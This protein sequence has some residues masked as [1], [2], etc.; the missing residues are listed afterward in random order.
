MNDNGPKYGFGEFTLD[1]ERAC[2]LGSGREVKLRPKVYDALRY[3][4]ENPGRLIRKEELIQALWPGSFVTDDSLVQCMVELRRALNDGAQAI[5]QTVPR[6]GY[7][8]TAAVRREET[9]K[10]APAA[11][12]VL[13]DLAASRH[14]L[15]IPRTP[16]IGRER[17][18]TA[19]RTLLLDPAIRLVTLTGAGGSGKTRLGL[20]VA[21][22]LAERFDG[23]VTFVALASIRDPAMAPVA[24]A[25]RRPSCPRFAEAAF[26]RCRPRAGAP[27]A[28]QSGAHS[29]GLLG[30]RRTAG[31]RAGPEISRN[32]QD[33]IACLR[34]A[35]I[36]GPAAGVARSET[37]KFAQR[38]TQ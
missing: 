27:G 15:P 28:G 32:Q 13:A 6:R 16:L 38:R 3:F 19:I 22:E 1:A 5:L 34:R 10:A 9:A 23:G 17:E 29:G 31:S 11:E 33:C 14:Y 18:L 35:R 7:L 8:F 12:T 24:I 4:V 36:S 37:V 2:L 21:G 30:G 20:E 26:P 25:V